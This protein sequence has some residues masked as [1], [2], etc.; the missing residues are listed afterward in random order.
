VYS[1]TGHHLDPAVVRLAWRVLG[2]SRFLTVSDTT[3]ALGLPDGKQRLGDQDV[4]IRDGAVRLADGTLAGTAASLIGCLREL[5]RVT[6]CSPDEALATATATPAR[7]M[8]DASRGRLTPGA[9]GDLVLLTED[10][11]VVATVVCGEVVYDAREAGLAL[12]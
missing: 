2:P 11:R 4:V 3:A 1:S 12:G 10:F 7:L 6:G 9:R 5:V 8:G